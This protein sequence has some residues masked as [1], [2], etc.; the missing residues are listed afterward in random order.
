V[1]LLLIF[2]CKRSLKWSKK[3]TDETKIVSFQ[4]SSCFLIY[5]EWLVLH[6]ICSTAF[7]NAQDISDVKVEIVD[8]HGRIVQDAGNL[9]EFKV[10]GEGILKGTD[11]GNP[12]DKTQMQ[13]KQRNAFNG[14]ALAVIQSTRINGKIRVTAVSSGLKDAVIELSSHNPAKSE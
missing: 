8:E 3:S 5:L 1:L 7:A 10:E 2:D 12:M 11:N 9:I 14:L 4:F 6:T 13:S